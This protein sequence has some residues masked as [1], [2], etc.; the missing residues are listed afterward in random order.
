[1]IFVSLWNVTE[2]FSLW[3]RRVQDYFLLAGSLNISKIP[4]PWW[5]D[6]LLR[7]VKVRKL[8][9]IT[10]LHWCLSQFQKNLRLYQRSVCPV[11]RVTTSYIAVTL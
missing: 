5:E 7:F 8:S 11:Y 3:G 10:V 9:E 1:M 4:G 2:S 6:E